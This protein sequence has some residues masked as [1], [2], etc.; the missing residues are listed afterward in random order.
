[1]KQQTMLFAALLAL[2]GVAQAQQVGSWSASVGVT[3]LAPDVSSGDLSA[4]SFIGTQVDVN[5]STALTGALNYAMTDHFVAH[6]PL[7]YGFKHKVTGAGAIAGA[8]VIATTKALPITFIGQYRFMSADA[9][10]RPYV[11]A[12]LT[13]ANFYDETGTG[14]LTA[15]TNP[16]GSATTV[17]FKDK[18]APTIQLGA[19]YNLNAK[20]YVDASYTKTMVKSTATLSTGQH[21]DVK[22]NPNGYTLQVGYKF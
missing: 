5:S 2:A 10:F 17:R 11:G 4:P 13:Y 22:L 8:G 7:A 9:T 12:G 20:W 18:L 21:I 1:M 14:T 19:T 3:K 6:L 15:L 16:G